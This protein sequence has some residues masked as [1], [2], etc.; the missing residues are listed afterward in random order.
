MKKL[1]KIDYSKLKPMDVFFSHSKKPSGALIRLAQT[2]SFRAV[3]D[4]ALPNHTGIVTESHGQLFATEMGPK[5]I[6]ENSL[7]KYT[8]TKNQIIRVF[9]WVGF[10]K[11]TVSEYGLKELSRLRRKQLD[12]DWFGA[13]LSSPLGKALF[14]WFAK[15]DKNSDFC[16]ENV[17]SILRKCGY[18]SFPLF[19]EKEPPSPLQMFYWLSRSPDFEEV[20]D[21]VTKQGQHSV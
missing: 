10:S 15:N 8:T 17:F 14:G 6:A 20:H 4:E 9:R 5:G 18:L 2:L 3:S 21:A 16:S 11:K 13:A 19:W 12:Y 1:L 7:E